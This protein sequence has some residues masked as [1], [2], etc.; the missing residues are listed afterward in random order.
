MNSFNERQPDTIYRLELAGVCL[1]TELADYELW[2]EHYYL[3]H[4]HPVTKEEHVRSIKLELSH[5][6]ADLF[7]DLWDDVIPF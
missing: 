4:D 1:E 5:I 7:D 2:Q 6:E 3:L